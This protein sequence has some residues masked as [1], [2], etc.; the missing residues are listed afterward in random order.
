MLKKYIISFS[1]TIAYTVLLAHNFTPHTHNIEQETHHHADGNEHH[2]H[3]SNEGHDEENTATLFHLFQHTGESAVVFIPGQ[4]LQ[5]GIQKKYFETFAIKLADFF[6]NQIEK[7]LLLLPSSR[8]Q[9]LPQP[10]TLPYFF[11][12]K[13]P[14]AFIS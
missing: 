8:T 10:Q 13:A 14:P 6:I 4:A 9:Y 11:L 1:L 7:T 5:T 2:H 12:L 3:D